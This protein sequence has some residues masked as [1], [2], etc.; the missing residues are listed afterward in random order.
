MVLDL[1]IETV[2]KIDSV[3]VNTKIIKYY[4]K[5]IRIRR[6]DAQIGTGEWETKPMENGIGMIN[7]KAQQNNA[8]R[9]RK[10][11]A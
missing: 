5:I 6:I 3:L 9:K 7:S 11:R 8:N 10:R 4:K 1:A 2:E